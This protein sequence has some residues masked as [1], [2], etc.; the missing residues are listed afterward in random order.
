MIVGLHDGNRI[1][2][3]FP[4]NYA[5][6]DKRLKMINKSR[7]AWFQ[8]ELAVVKLCQLLSA[9]CLTILLKKKLQSSC[10][11]SRESKKA[12]QLKEQIKLWKEYIN[13]KYDYQYIRKM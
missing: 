3:V 4:D 10:L 1:W 2:R 7:T 12:R 6:L 9:P 5:T 8:L 13:K 11:L